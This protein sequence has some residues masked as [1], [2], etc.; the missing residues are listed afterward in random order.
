MSMSH[1]VNKKA[2]LIISTAP[3]HE[4]PGFHQV[5]LLFY[6]K[7]FTKLFLLW[8]DYFFNLI[9]VGFDFAVSCTYVFLRE[10]FISPTIINHKKLH[11]YTYA[12]LPVWPLIKSGGITKEL[13]VMV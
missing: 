13:M 11:V 7:Y 4:V 5:Y 6:K 10:L 9:R 8:S 2:P 3:P 12:Y 1:G